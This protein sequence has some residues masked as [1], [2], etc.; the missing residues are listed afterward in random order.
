[1]HRGRGLLLAAV[2]FCTATLFAADRAVPDSPGALRLRE[3]PAVAPYGTVPGF[4]IAEFTM[5]SPAVAFL[6]PASRPKKVLDAK[7]LLLIAAG[8]ALTVADY[9]LTQHCLANRTCVET[10]PLL[11]TSRA[12]MYGTNVPLNAALYFWSYRR[13]EHGKRLWWVAPLAV[14]ASHA[15]GVGTNLRI[16]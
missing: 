9:E 13:K 10:D 1:M 14:A 16:R 3:T 12:G 15:V 8:T 11:P 5:P 4:D 6:A 7:F 2:M